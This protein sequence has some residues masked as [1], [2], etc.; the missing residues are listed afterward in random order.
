MTYEIHF[1]RAAL[2]GQRRI[3]RQ[4]LDRIQRAIE[5]LA[6]DPRPQ[7]TKALTGPLSGHYR[8]RL[9]APGGEYR[10]LYRVDDASRAVVI[11]NIGSR[12]DIY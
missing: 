5:D 12:E 10:V 8:L 1:E 4:A 3:Q 11:V 6:E 9:S 2:R 7:G